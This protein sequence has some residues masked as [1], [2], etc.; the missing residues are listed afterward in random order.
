MGFTARM[1]AARRRQAEEPAPPK[2]SWK[3]RRRMRQVMRQMR[4]PVCPDC[5]AGKGEDCIDEDGLPMT[6][7]DVHSSRGDLA[8]PGGGEAVTLT[9]RK[10]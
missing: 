3:L 1:L 9:S 7:S 2:A 4:A 10:P 5:Q 6:G 8:F